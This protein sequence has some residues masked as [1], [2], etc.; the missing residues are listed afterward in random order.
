MNKEHTELLLYS[1]MSYAEVITINGRY[2][3]TI[4]NKIT[5]LKIY[6]NE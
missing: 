3:N 5:F 6:I 1:Y 4:K 2:I